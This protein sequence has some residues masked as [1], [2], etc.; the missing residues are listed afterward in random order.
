MPRPKSE[1]PTPGELEVLK[2]L[3]ERGP[4]TI[5]Q[6]W[7]VLDQR[8]RRHYTTVASLL[9][10]MAQKG[11]VRGEAQRRTLVYHAQ[12]AR[13]QT[14]AEM[15]KDFVDRAFEGSASALVL[16]VLDQCRPSTEEMDEIARLLRQHRKRQGEQP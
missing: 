1:H 7:E 13:H 15:L 5:R 3:W 11:L 6:I 4:S 16:Q 2:I 14:R 10:T 9:A 12:T 8:R